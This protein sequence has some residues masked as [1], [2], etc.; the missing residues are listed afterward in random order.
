MLTVQNKNGLIRKSQPLQ[1]CRYSQH[2]HFFSPDPFRYRKNYILNILGPSSSIKCSPICVC[3]PVQKRVASTTLPLDEKK[4]Q[5]QSCLFV[6][7]IASPHDQVLALL[8]NTQ[9]VGSRTPAIP[10]LSESFCCVH[11]CTY[12]EDSPPQN[13]SSQRSHSLMRMYVRLPDS[14]V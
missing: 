12:S 8:S 4:T 9:R 7:L 10:D 3:T 11:S 14:Y 1:A 6:C 5:E 2:A 13:R